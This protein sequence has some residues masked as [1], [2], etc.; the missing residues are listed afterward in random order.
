MLL[1][2]PTDQWSQWLCLPFLPSI[3]CH[4]KNRKN[5]KYSFSGFDLWLTV[6]PLCFFYSISMNTRSYL[7]FSMNYSLL[8]V[9][10]P[11]IWQTFDTQWSGPAAGRR[12]TR[13]PTYGAIAWDS[14][15]CLSS[16]ILDSRNDGNIWYSGN[17]YGLSLSTTWFR[18]RSDFEA[19]WGREEVKIPGRCECQCF[20]LKHFTPLVLSV[21]GMMGVECDAGRRRLA[22]H[23]AT[24]WKR[25]YSE[26]CGFVR[27]RLAITYITLVWYVSRCLHWDRNPSIRP[28]QTIPDH[29][30]CHGTRVRSSHCI[31]EQAFNSPIFVYCWMRIPIWNIPL[32]ELIHFPVHKIWT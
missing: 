21:D 2:L 14:G 22:S 5:D 24:K 28:S 20:S 4:V 3:Q 27:S 29:P 26:V 1:F 31:T 12:S 18:S 7:F 8:W 11:C 19:P 25:T 6:H 30:R 15:W 13:C 16:W 23:L 32:D 9:Q 10:F 17:G